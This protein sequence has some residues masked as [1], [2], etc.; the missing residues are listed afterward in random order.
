MV[1]ILEC[2]IIIVRKVEEPVGMGLTP[3]CANIGQTSAVMIES[4]VI[5][6]YVC[7]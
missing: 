1:K 7:Y 4:L 5:N 6:S 3:N 2:E